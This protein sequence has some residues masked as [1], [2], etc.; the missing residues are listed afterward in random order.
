MTPPEGLVQLGE[1]FRAIALASSGSMSQL[2]YIDR[3]QDFL[4]QSPWPAVCLRSV[5]FAGIK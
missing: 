1:M 4:E 5:T 3:P 2:F